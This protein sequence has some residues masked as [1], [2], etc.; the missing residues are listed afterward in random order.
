MNGKI[1]FG[2][3]G[4]GV[5]SYTHASAIGNIEDAE[6]VSILEPV[7]KNREAFLAKHNVRAY[8]NMDDFLADPELDAVTIATPSGIHLDM[9]LPSARAGKHVLCEKPL[10]ITPERAQSLIDAC[11]ENKVVLAPVF[12]YRH[13]PATILIKKAL[14]SGRF[15]KIL[16]AS[17]RIKWYRPQEYY[18]SGG[19]RGTWRL[20][21][22]GCL[23]NQ[24]IHA[25]DLMIHFAGRPVEAYGYTGTVDHA[26]IEAEDNAAAVVKFDSGAF[27]VIE[28]ST[29]CA[30]GWPLKVEIS[31]TRGSAAVEA[32]S[33]AK[34]S[35]ADREPLDDE[36][37][38]LIEDAAVAVAADPRGIAPKN[39]Q[40]II[41]GMIKTIKTRRK[42]FV[43]EGESAKLGLE[44]ICG[45][46]RS[47]KD[48]KPVKFS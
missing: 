5:I 23:M 26:G 25:I 45:I 35:F 11:R 18:D 9:V 32:T 24:S 30:P 8:E 27:G 39:H 10:D 7:K 2:I 36:A 19:W 34:W 46:Y 1:R 21:G 33:L 20:D 47:M 12:Q 17:A 37:A 29:C 28:S 40:A 38:K 31:G 6:L 16:L 44:L 43:I 3:I 42:G 41:E 15:G 13:I 48:G 14:D 22:G 4:T